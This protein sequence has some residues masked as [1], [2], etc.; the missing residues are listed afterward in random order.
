MKIF[1]IPIAIIF[2]LS[3]YAQSNLIY[4]NLEPVKIIASYSLSYQEDSTNQSYIRNEDMLLLMGKNISKFVSKT[5]FMND[6]ITRKFSTFE[7]EQEYYMNPQ[8]PIP[9]ILYKIYKN[10]P[11]GQLT[12]TEYIPSSYFSYE[13]PMDL[14]HWNL[15]SD[16]TTIC[17][18]KSQKATCNF[19]GRNWIA[20]FAAELPFGDGPY[21]FNGLPGLII[22]VYDTHNHYAFELKSI[23][24]PAKI[25]MI[26]ILEEK[27]VVTTK[28]SFFKAQDS[29][30][31]DIINRAKQAGGDN[32][33][34]QNVARNVAQRNNP[35]ELLRK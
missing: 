8:R 26:E 21:K 22:K 10:Y 17:G 32:D 25:L 28:Q 2:S 13:E 20:W 23:G 18:Y 19:G 5:D 24:K 27:Y 34:Q 14:F 4:K 33:F 16:T 11:K 12:Y 31:A 35:I 3:S 1:F 15:T 9:R 7:Q 30:Y 29:F 6:T